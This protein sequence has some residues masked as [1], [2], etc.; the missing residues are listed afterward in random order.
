MPRGF[1]H[2]T[3]EEHKAM[4]SRGGKNNERRHQFTRDEAVAAGRK[5]A[6]IRAEKR[7]AAEKPADE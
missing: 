7:K 2:M 5:G 3:P 1:G 6:R 4:S